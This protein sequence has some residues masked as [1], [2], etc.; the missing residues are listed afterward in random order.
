M[1]IKEVEKKQWLYILP[2]GSKE[3]NMKDAKIKLGVSKTRLVGMMKS[4][5]VKRI[6]VVNS[7]PLTGYDAKKGI[8]N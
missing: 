1:E 6:E 7:K 4:E 8:N 5:V 2:D 3:Y